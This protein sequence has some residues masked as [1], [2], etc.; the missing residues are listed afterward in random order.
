M[1]QIQQYH[2]G[3]QAIFLVFGVAND[4]LTTDCNGVLEFY[5][6]SAR[7]NVNGPLAS[8]SL[9]IVTWIMMDEPFSSVMASKELKQSFNDSL[10]EISIH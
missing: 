2:S 4:C 5:F 8:L 10:L 9:F 3:R 7:A 6:S 1:V